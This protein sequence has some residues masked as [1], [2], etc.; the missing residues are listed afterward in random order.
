MADFKLRA[1]PRLRFLGAFSVDGVIGVG[2]L[3]QLA[4]GAT[5]RAVGQAALL[6][7][8]NL[9]GNAAAS[10]QAVAALLK[11]LRLSSAGVAGAVGSGTLAA[12]GGAWAPASISLLVGA[13]GLP[14]G[15]FNV[16]GTGP[17]GYVSGGISGI[18]PAG[19]QLP[20]GM[21]ITEAG[22]LDVG[23][24]PEAT[25]TGVVFSY[26]EPG[27]FAT[28]TLHPTATGTLP[29]MA[30]WYPPEGVVPSGYNVF[31]P[32][33]ANLR[34]TILSVWPDN[35]AQVIVLA[36]ETAVTNGS[37]KSIRLRT[38]Q[39]SAGTAL[40]TARITA[41]VSS[42]AVNFGGGVQT[43]SSF[44]SPDRVWWANSR[45]ICARYRLSCNVGV[46]EAVIDI[47]AFAGGVSDRA[48]VEVVIENGKFNAN[49]A[50]QPAP[51]NQ[52]YTNATVSVN[53][54][55]IATVSSGGGPQGSHRGF[56]AWYASTWV[57]GDPGIEVTH[58]T[59]SLYAHPLFYKYDRASSVNLQTTY[60]SSAYSPWTTGL[61][62]SPG[63]GAGGDQPGI[64]P[65]TQWD[66]RYL[67][68]GDKH[69]RRASITNA[70]AALTFNINYRHAGTGSSNN[71][72]PT[73]DQSNGKFHGNGTW[74]VV[75]SE[76]LAAVWEVAH[77]PAE[78][79]VAF[80]CRPSP[81][82]IEIAQKI[83]LWNGTW[84]TGI[85]GAI[86]GTFG[87]WYQVRGKGWCMRSLAHAI[88]LTPDGDP[89]KQP[90][91]D[92]LTRNITQLLLFRD[93]PAN[94]LDFMWGG[95]PTSQWDDTAGGKHEA[96]GLMHLYFALGCH[97]AARAKVLT[98][99][100]QSNADALAAWA[101]KYPVR[102]VNETSGGSFRYIAIR[103]AIAPVGHSDIF[104]DNPN[105]DEYADYTALALGNYGASVPALQGTWMS[106]EGTLTD[107]SQFV[108]IPSASAYYPSYFWSVLTLAV[109]RDIAG[110]SSA[111]AKVT[112]NVAG[113][114]AWRDG[115]ATEPRWGFAPRNV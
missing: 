41:L 8:I 11:G 21:T 27:A 64:G 111:W 97:A 48:F 61:Q 58:D 85:T 16:Q 68:S 77:H 34:G 107:Y 55:T 45:V 101:C 72:V 83:A 19:T 96:S 29:Y 62:T 17:S 22:V 74:P 31:S 80:L 59:A 88:F 113:L 60:S 47:H 42:I 89:W 115:F 73:F 92:C 50:S 4:G 7:G 43:L 15:Q 98:G 86:D 103:W 65:F 104:S 40:T 79:L 13:A 36:G 9:A 32:D 3:N 63:M 112:T 20:A 105:F 44:G 78:G 99:S 93:S 2:G 110:A 106:G 12:S 14:A 49:A 10:S 114:S 54:S 38:G 28:L 6:R 91:K 108:A 100:A 33:D 90:A 102:W 51:A 1:S 75:G 5:A 67:Q 109:E 76:G 37:T 18:D 26:A 66:S 57:G 35:S 25:T 70:L 24:A 87:E 46:L 71:L 53:G 30:T 56:S 81:C 84:S 69:A 95:T 94:K 52:T 39:P 23:T 82:F